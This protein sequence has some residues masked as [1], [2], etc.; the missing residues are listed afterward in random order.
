M[1]D[2]RRD[3]ESP[4]V[5]VL[6]FAATGH[7]QNRE[8]CQSTITDTSGDQL[9][10]FQVLPAVLFYPRLRVWDVGVVWVVRTDLNSFYLIISDSC[11]SY[12]KPHVVVC[13]Y[14]FKMIAD[15]VKGQVFFM[16]IN[17]DVSLLT[18]A[19]YCSRSYHWKF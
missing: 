3:P 18:S 11:I 19:W 5:H 13:A 7:N 14:S 6:P 10:F 9:V 17:V 15:F 2:Y 1:F 4:P 12:G 16:L 8:C